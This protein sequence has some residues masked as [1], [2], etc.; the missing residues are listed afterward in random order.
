[1]IQFILKTIHV[2][3]FVNALIIS[4]I[5]YKNLNRGEL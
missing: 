5:V 4:E 1:M 3:I 2:F